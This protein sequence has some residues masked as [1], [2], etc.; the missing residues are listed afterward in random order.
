MMDRILSGGP[1]T[2]PVGWCFYLD[3]AHQRVCIR[4]LVLKWAS[5]DTISKLCALE[6]EDPDSVGILCVTLYSLHIQLYAVN[7]KCLVFHERV[8]FMWSSMLWITS[9][10]LSSTLGTLVGN[11]G[12]MSA[13]VPI[14]PTMSTG[15]EPTS[16]CCRCHD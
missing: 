4:S 1:L 9:L 12:D 11:V 13:C 15:I 8:N 2:L 3:L 6:S 16:P 5:F 10:G 7:S 14:T